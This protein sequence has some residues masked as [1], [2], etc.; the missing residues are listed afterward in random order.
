MVAGTLSGFKI[1]GFIAIYISSDNHTPSTKS[2]LPER[3]T[4]PFGN[5][6]LSSLG[7]DWGRVARSDD[8]ADKSS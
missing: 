2:I 5:E 8:G 3:I 7:G 6:I 1:D 4:L